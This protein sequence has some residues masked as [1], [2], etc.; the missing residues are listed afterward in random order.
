MTFM[1]VVCFP[2]L[3]CT[4]IKEFQEAKRLACL[5]TKSLSCL[6]SERLS[7][8]VWTSVLE[9][10]CFGRTWSGLSSIGVVIDFKHLSV[11]G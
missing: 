9:S 5:K 10:E 3:L 4:R 6:Y 11:R 8:C 7:S 1:H 2:H